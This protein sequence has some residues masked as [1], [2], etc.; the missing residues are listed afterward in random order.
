MNTSIELFVYSQT[1]N[2]NSWTPFCQYK[3]ILQPRIELGLQPLREHEAKQI[4]LGMFEGAEEE[5]LDIWLT[6]LYEEGY[7]VC[8]RVQKEVKE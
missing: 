7:E 8:K 4:K 5:V 6:R 1:I 3:K 2:I